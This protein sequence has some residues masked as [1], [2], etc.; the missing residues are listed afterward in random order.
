MFKFYERKGTLSLLFYSLSWR[1]YWILYDFMYLRHLPL[2][3][4]D[5][6]NLNLYIKNF[7][8]TSIENIPSI[9]SI[10]IRLYLGCLTFWH[11]YMTLSFMNILSCI[12]SYSE[13]HEVCGLQ[14]DMRI[15]KLSLVSVKFHNAQVSE[16]LYSLIVWL[17]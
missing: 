15:I 10:P 6:N 3:K 16:E 4:N 12:Y 8:I 1:L 17:N 7:Y 14:I 5:V 13:T 9:C 11:C 2:Y